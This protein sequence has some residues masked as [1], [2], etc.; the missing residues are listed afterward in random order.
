MYTKNIEDA[1]MNDMR[2][3]GYCDI[4]KA[5]NKRSEGEYSVDYLKEAVEMAE[6]K[7]MRTV[8]LFT[9]I[10]DMGSCKAGLL[11]MCSDRMDDKAIVVAGMDFD[12]E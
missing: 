1:E 7:G 9:D 2:T 11:A 4:K 6:E 3:V 10:H 8:F 5:H 12:H